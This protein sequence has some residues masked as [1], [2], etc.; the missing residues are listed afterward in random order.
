MSEEEQVFFIEE[1]NGTEEQIWERKTK[2]QKGFKVPEPII[3]IDAMSENSVDEITNFTQKLQR[4]NQIFLEQSE[5]QTRCQL[6]AKIQ[7]EEHSEKIFQQN[8]RY[9]HYLHN[10]DRLVLEDEKVT[11]QYYDETEQTK[12]HQILL[13]K[14]L[15]KDFVTSNTWHCT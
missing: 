8:I 7:K 10:F 2:S 11:R 1:D 12:Y 15:L 6:E 14:H 3:H 5:D 9:K 13:P 4:T